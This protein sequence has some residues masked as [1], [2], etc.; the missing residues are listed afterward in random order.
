MALLRP[1]TSRRRL[2]H[3]P[4]MR[5]LRMTNRYGADDSAACR[6][7][8]RGK[9]TDPV[10]KGRILQTDTILHNLIDQRVSGTVVESVARCSSAAC[11]DCKG[12]RDGGI[13]LNRQ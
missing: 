4:I 3:L 10:C 5:R 8:S 7:T 11:A 12:E 6:N 13:V 9:T 2:C 1:E